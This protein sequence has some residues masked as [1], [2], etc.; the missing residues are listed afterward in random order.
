MTDTI[1]VLSKRV[2]I[3]LAFLPVGT[4]RGSWLVTRNRAVD[5]NVK[6]DALIHELTVRKAGEY[7]TTYYESPL[8]PSDTMDLFGTSVVV[9]FYRV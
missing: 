2:A 6:R 7:W 4:P 1:M 8:D 5:Y 9:E 3:D